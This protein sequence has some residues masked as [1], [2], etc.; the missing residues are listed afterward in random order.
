MSLIVIRLTE[1]EDATIC[2]YYPYVNF[3]SDSWVK[4]AALYWPRMARIVPPEFVTRD[5]DT[6]RQL[7]DELDFVINVDPAAVVDQ[8]S[9]MLERVVSESS[10]ALVWRYGIKPM[11]YYLEP[12]L[13]RS[14]YLEVRTT[15]STGYV[16]KPVPPEEAWDVGRFGIEY[17]EP[18]KLARNNV[19]RERDIGDGRPEIGIAEESRSVPLLKSALV[20]LHF[21]ETT[22]NLRGLLRDHN[23]AIDGAVPGWVGVSPTLAWVYLSA[24]AGV[25]SAHAKLVPVT[26]ELAEHLGSDN[27]DATRM[28]SALLD[29]RWQSR[30]PPVSLLAHLA[31][32]LVIPAN[33]DDVPAAKIVRLRSRYAADFDAFHD[34][35][36]KLSRDLESELTE[37]RDRAV[38][39]AYLE[40]AVNMRFRRPLRDLRTALRSLGMDTA[41][42]TANAKFELPAALI[43]AGGVLSDRPVVAGSGAVAFALLVLGRSA[44]KARSAALTPSASS[45]L[46][47][48][49]KKVNPRSLLNRI[50]GFG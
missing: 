24:L 31:L 4:A 29:E 10:D 36:L 28:A 3:A 16:L 18:Y 26:D 49:D 34:E 41:F 5:S 17:H 47:R 42:A 48:I 33:L 44:T 30:E 2:A 27:W 38:L 7:S 15:R 43:A 13:T 35:V 1:V 6:V 50:R 20:G 23:L 8:V 12:R 40:N 14:S 19:W 11:A 21:Y 32:R 22:P 46:F 25:L 9:Y 39:R 45:Y 37:L